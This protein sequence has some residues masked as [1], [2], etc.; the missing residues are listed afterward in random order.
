MP[1]QSNIPHAHRD[2]QLQSHGAGLKQEGTSSLSLCHLL[3]LFNRTRLSHSS[4]DPW[5]LTSDTHSSSD[6]KIYPHPSEAN[7]GF[8]LVWIQ[9]WIHMIEPF[10]I[11]SKCTETPGLCLQAPFKTMQLQPTPGITWP[12]RPGWWRWSSHWPNNGTLN[13][14]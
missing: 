7:K 3:Q 5:Y 6:T 2:T 12:H 10:Q 8:Q 1:I 13:I 14:K 9:P 4:K 11:I